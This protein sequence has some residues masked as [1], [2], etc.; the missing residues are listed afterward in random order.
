MIALLF[1]FIILILGIIVFVPVLHKRFV[2]CGIISIIII[3]LNVWYECF[4]FGFLKCKILDNEECLQLRVLTW[5]IEGLE[6]DTSK[7]EKKAELILEQNADVVFLSEVFGKTGRILECML[8]KKYTYVTESTLSKGHFFW[9]KYPLYDLYIV[10]VKDYELPLRVHCKIIY[11][12]T[13]VHFYG[14][15]L[16]SNNYTSDLQ[17]YH[18]D[19]V[20]SHYEF[21][22]Y[23]ENIKYAESVREM[24]SKAILED[25]KHSGQTHTIIMGD[26]NDVSGSPSLNLLKYGGFND[27][28]WKGGIG[29]GATIFNPLPFRI[30]HIMYGDGFILNKIRIIDAE[31]LS[32]H[33]ALFAELKLEKQL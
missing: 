14:C 11:K 20:N 31:G 28:W 8:S 17:D 18:L 2:V 22:Q 33:N 25:I 24:E 3:V 32:D 15:H 21:K 1:P 23:I 19:R 16:A 26:F 29:Y 12:G 27:A 5:N 30:D 4:S 6:C 7:I 10:P 9:S 13:I